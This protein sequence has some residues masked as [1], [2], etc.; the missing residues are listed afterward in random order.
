M[1]EELPNKINDEKFPITSQNG[2]EV[3]DLIEKYNT[4]PVGDPGR[5]PIYE[6]IKDDVS[7]EAWE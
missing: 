5:R 2:F 6:K 1:T 4:L 7:Y 3:L